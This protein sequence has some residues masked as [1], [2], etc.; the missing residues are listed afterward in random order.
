M[1]RRIS[2]LVVTT[3]AILGLTLAWAPPSAQ[4]SPSDE[5]ACSMLSASLTHSSASTPGFTVVKTT[6]LYR[7]QP[8]PYARL[9]SGVSIAV[10]APAGM[11]EA[12][13]HN[14]ARCVSRKQDLTT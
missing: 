3:A 2:S 13:L 6:N 11:T 7:F 5:I 14:A 12:D 1:S 4:A 9:P 10:R 8:K